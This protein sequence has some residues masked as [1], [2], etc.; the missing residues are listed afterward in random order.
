MIQFIGGVPIMEKNQIATWVGYI[1]AVIMTGAYIPGVISIWKLRPKP[2]IAVSSRMYIAIN[3]GIFLWLIYGICIGSWPV[4][5][6]NL[7]TLP[8]SLSILIYKWLYG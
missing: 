1:A 3:T 7:V 8:L 4:I 6:S 5:I 2:A